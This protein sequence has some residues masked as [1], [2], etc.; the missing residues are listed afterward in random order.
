MIK[1]LII[2]WTKAYKE[3]NAEKLKA[4]ECIKNANQMKKV[5]EEKQEKSKTV[6]KYLCDLY[7][8][9]PKKPRMEYV[10]PTID[11]LQYGIGFPC[12]QSRYSTYTLYQFIVHE[13]DNYI[14]ESKKLYK[15]NNF[16]KVISDFDSLVNYVKEKLNTW[17]T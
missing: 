4:K 14:K 6:F 7:S 8:S 1:E 5:W 17:D 13:I 12:N 10:Q 9:L 2:A 16:I 15:Q 3:V 11:L